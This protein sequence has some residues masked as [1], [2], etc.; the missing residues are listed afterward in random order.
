MPSCW[1]LLK[2]MRLFLFSAHDYHGYLFASDRRR[3]LAQV[4][5]RMPLLDCLCRL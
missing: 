5:K 2:S 1:G 4:V 3:V